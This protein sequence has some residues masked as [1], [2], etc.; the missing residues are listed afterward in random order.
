MADHETA[1]RRLRAATTQ[2][3]WVDAM[4]A[5]T[6]LWR[7]ARSSS[8]M[9][10]DPHAARLLKAELELQPSHSL[11]DAHCG[12][13][14]DVCAWGRRVAANGGVDRYASVLAR[15][16]PGPHGGLLS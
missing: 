2:R 7:V 4:T 13:H 12:S 5:A 11:V 16:A 1:I 9:G 14:P 8:Y 10:Y 15:L 3:E 6:G